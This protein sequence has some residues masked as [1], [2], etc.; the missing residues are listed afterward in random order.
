[1]CNKTKNGYHIIIELEKDLPTSDI[2]KLQFMLGDDHKRATFNITRYL[3]G[4]DKAL[5]FNYFFSYKVKNTD[6]F[7]KRAM[8]MD[9]VI[10]KALKSLALLHI[11]SEFQK[12]LR[13]SDKP[14]KI[15]KA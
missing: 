12:P 14:K 13:V 3:L 6:E 7:I 1:V 4:G 2:V 8:L 5:Y 10:R 11:F 9:S 15:K